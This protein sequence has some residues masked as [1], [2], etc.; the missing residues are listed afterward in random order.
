[1][2]HIAEAERLTVLAKSQSDIYNC[3]KGLTLA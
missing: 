3:N 2:I 1:M